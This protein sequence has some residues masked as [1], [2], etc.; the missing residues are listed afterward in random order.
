MSDSEVWG[1]NPQRG[2]WY[3]AILSKRPFEIPIH[4]ENRSMESGS[5][6]PVI[7]IA[8]GP[9]HFETNDSVNDTTWSPCYYFPRPKIACLFPIYRTRDQSAHLLRSSSAQ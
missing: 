2:L 8:G 9:F 3:F 5:S 7:P 4:W 1:L 6:L